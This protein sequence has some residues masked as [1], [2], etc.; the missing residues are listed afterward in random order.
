M[1]ARTVDDPPFDIAARAT[2]GLPLSLAVV[3]GPA[4]LD[5]RTIRLTGAPGLVIVRASQ[6]GDEQFLPARTAERAFT[7]RPRPVA[8]AIV[9]GPMG[10]RVLIGEAV[11]L[12]VDASGEPT[13]E[14]Q[15]R[16]DGAPIAGATGR[17]FT[18]ASAAQSDAGSYDAVASNPLG[19]AASAPARLTV[20]KRQQS[21]SFQPAATAVAAGQQVVLSAS[22]TSGLPVRFEVVSGSASLNGELLMSPGGLVSVRAIQ[23]GDSTYE[24]ALSVTLTFMFGTGVGQRGP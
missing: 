10:R 5:G 19:S 18:I 6:D 14:L 22:A 16:K 15:W 13:P 17:T 9:S 12:S 11:V 1:A 21:I 4:V 23:P 2:S 24:P 20:G 3:A 7:V 8:P